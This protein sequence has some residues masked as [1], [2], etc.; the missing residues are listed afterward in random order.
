MKITKIESVL[1]GAATPGVG[2][3]SNRNYHFV[4]VHTDEGI[5]GLGEATLESHDNAVLGTLKDIECLVLGEDPTRIEHLTQ[6]MVR[7]L[8]WKG[9]VIKGSAIAGVELALWDILGKVM[10]LPVY[11]LLGGACRERIKVYVN[12]WSGGSLDPAVVREKA[13]KAMAAG[14]DAFKFSLAL[15]VWNV[16]DPANLRKI[17]RVAKTLRETAGPDA[18]LMYDG[19]GRYDADLAVRV[20]RILEEY[21]YTFFEEPCQPEQEE[22]LA[23]VASRLDIPVAAGERLSFLPEFKRLLTRGCATIIQPDIGHSCGFGTALKAAHLA[24]AF[25]AFVAPHGPMSPVIT[26]I[27]L[28]L[29]TLVPNFLIQERLFLND[30]RNE[31]ITEPIQVKDGYVTVPDKP[32]WGIELDEDIC[33]AH[34]AIPSYTPQ[35]T[36]PDG[37]VGDW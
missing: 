1:V 16:N 11:K 9:G 25:N 3:L 2:L 23:K 34:P 14:Y 8:F 27:S 20:G 26:T 17:E 28:H 10:G 24:E 30:W 21:D 31:V 18:M 33:T 15:P 7:Q 13:Q 5:T 29:D 37:A 32:G 35:L 19:H 36:R 6:K 12:G 22:S 4:R